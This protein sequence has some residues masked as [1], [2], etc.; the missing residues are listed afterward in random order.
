ML[1]NCICERILPL[2]CST[3]V[4]V[5]MDP[6]EARQPSNSGWLA[7][8]MLEGASCTVRG[9]K[10][11]APDFEAVRDPSRQAYLLFPAEGSPALDP[12]E[13]AADGRPVTLV[14]PD[15]CWSQARRMMRRE[16][17]LRLLPRRR[18]LDA[19]LGGRVM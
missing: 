9:L 16:P 17:D 6:R 11:V 14:V 13:L 4:V 8:D 15:A 3:R 18:L 19:A 10:D 12:A 1:G 7:V 5:V 2:A